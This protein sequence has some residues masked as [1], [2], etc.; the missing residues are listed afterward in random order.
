MTGVK[1]CVVG[2]DPEGVI[3]MGLR[4]FQLSFS[5]QDGGETDVGLS[6]TWIETKR[7]GKFLGRLV[8]PASFLQSGGIIDM[9]P[10]TIW[11][12]GSDQG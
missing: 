9:R 3:E 5:H 11:K 8:N 6:R 12:V 10:R 4:V 1:L 2:F 7:G